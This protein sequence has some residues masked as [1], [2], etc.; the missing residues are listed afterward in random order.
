MALVEQKTGQRQG[1]A[2]YVLYPLA[3]QTG[4]TCTSNAAAVSKS[5]CVFY[6]VTTGNNSVAC[7]AG[8][9]NCSIQ[10]SGGYGFLVS[11]TDNVTAAWT[12]GSGYD[13]ATGLGSINAANL[14]NKWTSVS[15]TPTTTTLSSLPTPLTHGQAV[16]FSI[17]VTSTGGT[18]SGDVSLIA[19]IGST[20]STG[21]GSFPLG[22]DG[23]F[24]GT[25][26][27]L[28]GGTYNVVAHYA[29]NGTYAASDS[30]ATA[31]T[32]NKESSQTELRLVTAGAA[33][34]PVYTV[35][36]APYGSV[37]ILRMDVTNSSGNLCAPASSSGEQL[38]P[39]YPCPTG[40]LTV[41]P[42]PKDVNAPTG[43]VPG[44]YTLNSQGYAEDVPIQQSPGVYNFVATYA[45]DNSYNGS[46][47]A[48]V[49]I[50]ITKAATTVTISN[51]PSSILGS[52]VVF[53]ANI[54]T[55]SNGVAPTGTVQFL[56]NGVPLG[57]PVNVNGG[58]P[59]ASGAYAN[60]QAGIGVDLPVGANSI[61][62]QYSGD[63]NYAGATSAAVAVTNAD[64]GL[65]ANPTAI[66][67][68]GPG[69]SGTS[70]ITLTPGGGL[71]AA[72]IGLS[73]AT[74]YVGTNCTISPSGFYPVG[75][76]VLTATITI[77][78][79]GPASAVSS[80]RKASVPPGFRQSIGWP[81]LLAGFLALATLVSLAAAGRR[82][83][84]WLFATAMLVVGAWAACGGGGGGGGVSPPP[85]PEVNLS[86]ASLTLSSPSVGVTSAA[87]SVTLYNYGN[88]SLSISSIALGGPNSTDFGETSN[89][90]TSVA[91]GAGCAIN[92]TF[93]PTATGSRS[94]SL[95]IA[96]N[97][98]G[99]P[100]TVNL[101]GSVTPMAVAS[102]TPT[103]L[104]F[105][106]ANDGATTPAQTLTLANTG[107]AL[108]AISSL[109]IQ[110]TNFFDFVQT[111]NCGTNVAAGAN[112]AISVQFRPTSSGYTSTASVAVAD[113]A[114]GSPQSAG[115][116][117]TAL[118]PVTPL[119]NFWVN[120]SAEGEANGAQGYQ[121][122]FHEVQLT[123]T[124]N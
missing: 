9:K 68:A 23:T 40:S 117:G 41:T 55:Q 32:V 110:G 10:T 8:T 54:N 44:S 94:A 46:T 47:S 13:L 4:A 113:N 49:P 100:Q 17:G 91:T 22:S 65:T 124:V 34:Y 72:T 18:P 108:L 81:W 63:S 103:S 80:S 92:V 43:T 84:T 61:S 48:A 93:T 39:V 77:T 67:L 24:T 78:T 95:T 123:V 35:T 57:S 26:N 122:W 58:N 2:G 71:T 119:G 102:L 90:G 116:T 96:D 121:E 79:T 88:A 5:N 87:Q 74:Q 33:V 12:A 114:P 6:D 99:S 36:T 56:S 86:P 28:P 112:C 16:S 59:G 109:T 89:C 25:T 30:A 104:S 7:V 51:L 105:G 70:T 15:F 42:A 50:T 21:I 107:S 38:S 66:S 27:M 37:Y 1:N 31:V 53:Y 111:N 118:P 83:T 60:A 45:G 62:V 98:S 97:A 115:L 75:S 106:Q 20:P 120:V 14:V 76:S 85:V 101:T 82:P 64:F 29:G 11:P 73:C 69:Q 3:A 19:E 52:H